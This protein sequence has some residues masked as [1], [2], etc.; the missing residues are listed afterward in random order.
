L[1]V[2][3]AYPLAAA[4]Y[5]SFRSRLFRRALASV[6]MATSS[7]YALLHSGANYRTRLPG[8]QCP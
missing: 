6:H 1:L 7:H 5:S 2:A 4:I 3:A 8:Q